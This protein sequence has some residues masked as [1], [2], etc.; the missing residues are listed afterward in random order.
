LHYCII[1]SRELKAPEA[2]VSEPNQVACMDSFTLP[3]LTE[4][5]PKTKTHW[6]YVKHSDSKPYNGGNRPMR[7]LPRQSF[8]TVTRFRPEFSQLMSNNIWKMQI[9][10]LL[11]V[12]NAKHSLTRLIAD[13]VS[14]HYYVVTQKYADI[15]SLLQKLPQQY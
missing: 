14:H 9:L 2:L 1:A 11:T 4:D 8:I 7:S 5:S 15:S 12:P 6:S 13:L 10:Y 3:I